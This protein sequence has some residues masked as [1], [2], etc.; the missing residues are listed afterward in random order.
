VKQGACFHTR[1]KFTASGVSAGKSIR[2]LQPPAHFAQFEPVKGRDRA[3]KSVNVID[4]EQPA[5]AQAG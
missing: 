5:D 2:K 4:S 1:R 3:S